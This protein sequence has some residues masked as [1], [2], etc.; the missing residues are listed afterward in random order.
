MRSLMKSLYKSSQSKHCYALSVVFS[1]V[2]CFVLALDSC[3]VCA[4]GQQSSN[5]M[6]EYDTSVS[7]IF[8]FNGVVYTQTIAADDISNDWSPVKEPQVLA[9]SNMVDIAQ[10]YISGRFQNGDL[11]FQELQYRRLGQSQTWYCLVNFVYHPLVDNGGMHDTTSSQVVSLLVNLDGY[12]PPVQYLPTVKSEHIPERQPRPLDVDNYSSSV[13]IMN[14]TWIQNLYAIATLKWEVWDPS[15]QE[16]SISL[17]SVVMRARQSMDAFIHEPL[18]PQRIVLMPFGKMGRFG[19]Y[20]V[21][22]SPSEGS[23]SI[24][25]FVDPNGNV[26]FW[27]KQ[28]RAGWSSRK[29]RL[30]PVMSRE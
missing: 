10:K 9:I 17:R 20:V 22:D 23:E 14:D 2:A 21:F 6:I 19:Y 15:S 5:H 29:R 8:R 4:M 25:V 3:S 12:V 30:K 18:I 27:E 24:K 1:A 11:S 7:H 28:S 16:P 26:P 13:R